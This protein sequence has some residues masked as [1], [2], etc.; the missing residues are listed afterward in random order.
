MNLHIFIYIAFYL[1]HTENRKALIFL[2]IYQ[3][4]TY[5]FY[6]K[7]KK[8]FLEYH[9]EKKNKY[10]FKIFKIIFI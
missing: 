7:T 6:K 3:K 4:L 2:K 10:E 8:I 9:N 1:F 5:R